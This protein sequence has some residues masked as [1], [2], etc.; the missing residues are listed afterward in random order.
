[1]DNISLF[2]YSLKNREPMFDDANKKEKIIITKNAK[3][4]NDIIKNNERLIA[5]ITTYNTMY[6]KF[7]KE[8]D[9]AIIREIDSILFKANGHMNYTTFSQYLMVWDVSYSVLSKEVEQ[10]RITLHA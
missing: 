8:Q 9:D 7:T 4:K 5:L 6:G 10:E 2:E 1:M 3:D